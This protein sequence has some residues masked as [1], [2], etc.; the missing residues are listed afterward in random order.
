MKVLFAQYLL[1]LTN[2]VLLREKTVS[3]ITVVNAQHVTTF[4]QMSTGMS[5]RV[6]YTYIICSSYLKSTKNIKSILFRICGLS[7]LIAMQSFT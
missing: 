3:Y 4:W 2:A 6:I 1:M 5:L 7:V